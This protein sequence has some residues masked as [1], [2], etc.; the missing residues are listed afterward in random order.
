MLLRNLHTE[1]NLHLSNDSLTDEEKIRLNELVKF[2]FKE[3][4]ENRR[5][6][7]I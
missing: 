2:S 4:I 7:T 6:E 1:I 5:N 3:E